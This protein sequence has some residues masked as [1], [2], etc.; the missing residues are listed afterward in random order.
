MCLTLQEYKELHVDLTYENISQEIDVDFL[1]KMLNS[2]IL[3][4]ITGKFCFPN[5]F[6]R[7]LWR[8]IVQI[9]YCDITLKN[10]LVGSL[11]LGKSAG[12]I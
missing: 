12:I 4:Y 8:H 7:S 6:R 2:L 9:L 3:R 11:S 1:S 10:M 5:K